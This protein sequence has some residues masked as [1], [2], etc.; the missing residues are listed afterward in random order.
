MRK[1]ASD[2]SVNQCIVTT[3][4]S[5]CEALLHAA[6]S[7]IYA[8]QLRVARMLCS[9]PMTTKPYHTFQHTPFHC[10]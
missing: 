1:T 5:S 8:V 3:T 4:M 9:T 6:C 7:H 10:T 2:G